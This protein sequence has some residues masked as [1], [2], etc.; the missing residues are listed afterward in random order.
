MSSIVRFAAGA[1]AAMFFWLINL[2]V[3]AAG[4]SPTLDDSRR[5]V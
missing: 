5:G 4:P 3:H 1:C 2:A